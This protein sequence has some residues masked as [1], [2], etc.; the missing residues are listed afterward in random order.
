MTATVS[1]LISTG[2]K[3]SSPASTVPPLPPSAPTAPS[4]PVLTPLQR[5]RLLMD[6]AR[7]WG[8][9]QRWDSTSRGYGGCWSGSYVKV[10]V[11]KDRM[12]GGMWWYTVLVGGG[13]PW[14]LDLEKIG[15]GRYVVVH[16]GGR[17]WWAMVFG[18]WVGQW[19]LR[20]G[21][22]RGR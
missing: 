18:G 13:G 14:Q 22:R 16:S 5:H 7:C 20:I 19:E 6:L 2:D 10:K 1:K 21:G 17:W 11:E 12:G 3:L 15:W 9:R 8:G 4:Q